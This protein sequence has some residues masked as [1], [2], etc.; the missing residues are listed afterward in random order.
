MAILVNSLENQVNSIT[1][2]TTFNANTGKIVLVTLCIQT[3][4]LFCHLFG[5]KLSHE[6]GADAVRHGGTADPTFTLFYTL[7]HFWTCLHDAP[8]I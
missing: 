2:C 6:S 1:P 8:V 5:V 7:P 4:W 3:E